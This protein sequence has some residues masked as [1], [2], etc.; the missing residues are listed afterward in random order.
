MIDQRPLPAK[1][2][3]WRLRSQMRSSFYSFLRVAAGHLY[4]IKWNPARKRKQK[5]N[6]QTSPDYFHWFPDGCG[7][8]FSGSKFSSEVG[9][10]F[11]PK[12]HWGKSRWFQSHRIHAW[13]VYL[14]TWML[15]FYGKLVGKYTKDNIQYIYIYN[16]D[17]LWMV[18]HFHEPFFVSKKLIGRRNHQ[19]QVAVDHLRFH[20]IIQNVRSKIIRAGVTIRYNKI[21]GHSQGFKLNGMMRVSHQPSTIDHTPLRVSHHILTWYRTSDYTLFKTNLTWNLSLNFLSF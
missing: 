21:D 7:L 14:P 16:M 1:P 6:Q 19:N 9:M 18:R 10:Y 2:T 8:T 11:T 17:L 15:G 3:D 12:C 13:L 5:H 20:F 4:K